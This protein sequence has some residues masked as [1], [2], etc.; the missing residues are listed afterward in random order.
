MY[1]YLDMIIKLELIQKMSLCSLLMFFI[2]SL[3]INNEI[4][5]YNNDNDMHTID[6]NG[7]T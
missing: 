4:Y 5:V 3:S 1:L 6:K 7:M 2:V